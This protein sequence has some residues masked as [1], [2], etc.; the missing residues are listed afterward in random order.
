MQI[1]YPAQIGRTRTAYERQNLLQFPVAPNGSGRPIGGVE[2]R[3]EENPRAADLPPAFSPAMAAHIERIVMTL[4]DAINRENRQYVGLVGTSVEDRLF[5][6][7][8]I[9][10]RCPNVRLF[11][12]DNNLLY[13]HPKY[14]RYLEGMLVA[15]PFP[16]YPRHYA[17]QQTPLTSFSSDEANGVYVACRVVIS[18]VLGDGPRTGL[19]SEYA[20][21]FAHDAS[22][23]AVALRPPVWVVQVGRNKILPVAM[24]ESAASESPHARDDYTLRLDR[25][26]QEQRIVGLNEQAQRV[27][28]GAVRWTR[29]TCPRPT[30]I[31]STC[32]CT[33]PARSIAASWAASAC[34]C[35]W[36]WDWQR[37]PRGASEPDGVDSPAWLLRWRRPIAFSCESSG[38]GWPAYWRSRISCWPR[39]L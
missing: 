34:S 36:S 18:R 5:L 37:S 20:S 11:C 31:R 30:C 14:N 33:G 39:R 22:D 9:Y 3:L 27:G 17:G 15:S 25:M 7:Q 19:V 2:I 21:P 6:A 10:Y 16:L 1:T 13:T 24:L 28:L 23:A 35:C 4:L 29:Q 38:V 32:T 26:W 8:L 12:L